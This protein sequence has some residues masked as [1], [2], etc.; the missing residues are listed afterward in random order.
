GCRYS[1][2]KKIQ[3]FINKLVEKKNLRYD[4][5]ILHHYS[6]LA[7]YQDFSEFDSNL[8]LFY[9]KREQ[10]EIKLAILENIHI[11]LKIDKQKI[12]KIFKEYSRSNDKKILSLFYERLFQIEDIINDIITLED[13]KFFLKNLLFVPD[14]EKNI[15]NRFLINHFFQKILDSDI[16]CFFTFLE[17]RMDI[18]S[19]KRKNKEEFNPIPYGIREVIRRVKIDSST[20]KSLLRRVRDWTLKEE[21]FFNF[22]SPFI[23]ANICPK[24]DEDLRFV[25][26]EWI[27]IG[28][29][30]KLKK[31]A[32]LTRELEESDELFDLYAELIKI[33]RGNE[34]VESEIIGAI[35]T[36]GYMYKVGETPNLLSKRIKL[37]KEIVKT[38]DDLFVKQFFSKEID[39]YER[40]IREGIE[41]DKELF[42]I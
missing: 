20:R 14:F 2:P 28:E 36:S 41:K 31:V 17:E 11:F 21:Y 39:R 29:I 32:Y 6:F 40:E 22:Y 1:S 16:N 24:L 38:H 37:F 13:Y 42:G 15:Q 8:I 5:I 30:E 3:L 27:K 10:L 12:F 7:R 9:S 26:F 33:S 35:Y 19:T 23:L 34:T 25:L 4:L 18:A